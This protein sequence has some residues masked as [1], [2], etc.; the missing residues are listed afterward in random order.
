MIREVVQDPDPVLHK[1]TRPMTGGFGSIF[2]QKL[3]RD[4]KDTLKEQD[5]LGLAG[6]QIGESLA[7]FVI[8]EDIAPQVR[9]PKMPFT[10]IKPLEPTVFINPEIIYHSKDKEILEEGCLSIKGIFRPTPR[11][12]KIKLRALDYQ[13]RKLTITAEGLLARIFQHETDHLG[14]VLFIERI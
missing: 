4:M 5:G 10:L 9:T 8:P 6:P 13:G 12:Y 3:I 11:A 1:K 2:L 7:I 14:G